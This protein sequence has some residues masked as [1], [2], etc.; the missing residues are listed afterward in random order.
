MPAF[1]AITIND[2]AAT[3]VA[4]TFSPNKLIGPA[5]DFED[6]SG[7]IKSGYPVIKITANDPK[8]G[9]TI[10]KV[11]VEITVPTLETATGSTSGGFAP[12]PTKAYDCRFVGT[13]F[14][15]VR[16]SLQNRKDLRAYVKNLLTHSL[17]TDVVE[18]QEKLY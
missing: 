4:H 7:G 6:R 10:S 17:I 9:S 12:V 11:D 13:F 18:T 8:P 5:G 14:L 16:S 2:G 15:P 1:A 3:P